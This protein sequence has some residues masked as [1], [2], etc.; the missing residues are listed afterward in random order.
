MQPRGDDAR[1]VDHHEVVA[2]FLGELGERAVPGLPGPTIVHEKPRRVAPLGGS[3]G[4]EL[5][6]EV[7]VELG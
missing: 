1:V 2:G 5:G 4:D 7:V 6:R 3:L